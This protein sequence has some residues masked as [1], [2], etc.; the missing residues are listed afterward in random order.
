MDIVLKDAGLDSLVGI[1]LVFI[2]MLHSDHYYVMC[3]NLKKG[4]VDV[5]DNSE[6]VML[7]SK[8]ER[9]LQIMVWI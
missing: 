5:I 4:Q 6:I 7:D 8:Y 3:F 2:P 9:K 1:E